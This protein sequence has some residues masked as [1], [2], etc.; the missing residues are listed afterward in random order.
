MRSTGAG[1]LLFVV[2]ATG[3]AAG[4]WPREPGH[5]FVS[6]GYEVTTLQ[7]ELN[8]DVAPQL[9]GYTTFYAE[10]GITPRLTGGIDYGGDET[11]LTAD[12]QDLYHRQTGAEALPAPNR[13]AIPNLRTWSNIVFLRYALSAPDAKHRFAVQLGAGKRRYTALGRYRGQLE[14]RNETIVRPALAYG[15]GFTAWDRP[16]WVSVEGSVEFREDTEGTGRKLDA[17]LGLKGDKRLTY[18]LQVQSGDFPRSDPYVKLQPG[19][20]MAL[21]AGFAVESAVIWGV[22]G[23]DSVGA[24]LALWWEF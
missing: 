24:K 20:V 21:P 8:G 11:A 18:M 23:D 14:A 12:L 13:A 15:H 10:F 22:T 5:G 16:G 6:L 7:E 9:D 1:V 19:I 4:A 2:W 3:A 17:T